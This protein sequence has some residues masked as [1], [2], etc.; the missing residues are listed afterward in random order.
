MENHLGVGLSTSDVFLNLAG[1]IKVYEPAC[2]I[3]AIAAI[4][5]AIK[6]KQIDAPTVFIGEVG[7]G[8][9][10]RSVPLLGRRIEEAKRFGFRRAIIPSQQVD[11]IIG[12]G[13]IEINSVSSVMQAVKA[14]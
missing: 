3:G 14:I 2:D 1:G 10:V 5:S 7:L 12:K 9:E 8:G 6:K 11:S 13:N 4:Y